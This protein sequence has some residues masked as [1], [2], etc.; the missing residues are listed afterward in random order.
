MLAICTGGAA[1]FLPLLGERRPLPPSQDRVTGAS[2]GNK[3]EPG[4]VYTYSVCTPS[5]GR[6]TPNPYPIPPMHPLSLSTDEEEVAWVNCPVMSSC[7]KHEAP[8]ITVHV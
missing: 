4:P 6:A 7:Y 2:L 3:M 5:Q 1:P 8:S